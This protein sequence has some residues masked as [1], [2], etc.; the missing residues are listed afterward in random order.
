MSDCYDAQR[1]ALQD[2]LAQL[3]PQY[4]AALIQSVSTPDALAAVQAEQRAEEIARRM[5]LFQARLDRLPRSR[6]AACLDSGPDPRGLHDYL[7]D[8]V[9][10][11][12]FKRVHAALETLLAAEVGRVRAGL[13]L[14][15]RCSEMNGRLCAARVRESLRERTGVGRFVHY[16]IEFRAAL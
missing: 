2:A 11:V 6:S 14:L 9:H 5:E 12:D 8:K 7:R 16:P 3:V 15:R 4:Q 13:L 1:A 10:L